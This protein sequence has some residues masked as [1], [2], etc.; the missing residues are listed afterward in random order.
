MDHAI[1]KHF[2]SLHLKLWRKILTIPINWPYV[3]EG[4]EIEVK[5]LMVLYSGCPQR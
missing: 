1:I 2:R 3:K 5:V 4:K